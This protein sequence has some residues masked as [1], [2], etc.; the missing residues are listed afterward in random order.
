[1]QAVPVLYQA[2]YLTIAGYDEERG[3]FTLDYPNEEVRASFSKCLVDEY[4]GVGDENLQSFINRFVDAVYDVKIDALMSLLQA[5]IKS[6]PYDIIK[7]T[8][9]FFQVVIHLIFKMLG[10]DC[11]SEVR[12]ADGRVDTMLKTKKLLYCFEF[13]FDK[14]ADEA[15]RQIDTKDYLLPWKNDNGL[16]LFKIGVNFSSSD[17]NIDK[18]KWVEMKTI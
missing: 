8:E 14:S 18:W 15:L 3:R 6:I 11:E 9:N 1:M 16:R 7:D 4:F 12:L 2:G 13:K 5:F 17:R 10:F